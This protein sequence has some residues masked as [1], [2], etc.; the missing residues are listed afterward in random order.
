MGLFSKVGSFL[1]GG[2]SSI[3]A[4]P[5]ASAL[6]QFGD[7]F[8]LLFSYPQL[9]QGMQMATAMGQNPWEYLD[10]FEGKGSGPNFL[11]VP[12]TTTSIDL[13]KLAQ[14]NA[15]LSEQYETKQLQFFQDFYDK[16]GEIPA[17]ADTAAKAKGQN[18]LTPA[19]TAAFEGLGAAALGEGAKSGFLADPL[20]QQNVLGPVAYQKAMTEYG[21]QQEAQQ[22]LQGLAGMGGIPG[23]SQN[24]MLG[25]GMSQWS[26]GAMGAA[27]L[28]GG[29][30]LQSA[31]GAASLN[32]QLQQ[33][34]MMQ[35]M[36]YGAGAI[37][38]FASGGGFQAL[39]G[40]FGF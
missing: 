10:Q 16:I 3:S 27:G 33:E 13:G 11:K 30:N 1:G 8:A 22:K 4:P 26:Q 31:F 39:G 32:T 14:G 25:G 24:A 15:A 18:L 5:Q 38:G 20:K 6:G 9:F 17:F 28:F 37:G 29:A 12:G 7:I 21:I 40:L 35:N 36:K 19:M 23:F 34:M 2:S